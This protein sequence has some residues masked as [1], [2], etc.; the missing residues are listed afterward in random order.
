MKELDEKMKKNRFYANLIEHNIQIID[1][2][3]IAVNDLIYQ[4]MEHP[5]FAIVHVQSPCTVYNDT[6]EALK[7][8]EKKGIAPIAWNIPDDHDV[9][10]WKAGVNLLDNGGI[11]IGLLYSSKERVTLHD[12]IQSEK[13][14][15]HD[16]EQLFNTYKV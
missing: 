5:G 9:T 8:N 2:C 15:V 13:L 12:K 3:L 4:G 14:P 11:P 6:F 10:D 1:D 7:G 16:V